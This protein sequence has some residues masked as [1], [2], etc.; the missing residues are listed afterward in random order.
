MNWRT[1][2]LGDLEPKRLLSISVYQVRQ[3]K[4]DFSCDMKSDQH[5]N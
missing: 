5:D 3:A 2:I 4:P 1:L